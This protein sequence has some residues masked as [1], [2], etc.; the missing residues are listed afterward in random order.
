MR[1]EAGVNY[2]KSLKFIKDGDLVVVVTGIH[3]GAGFTNTL[4]LLKQ[5]SSFKKKTFSFNTR[6]CSVAT[7]NL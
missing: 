6:K 1:V 5:Q 2:G 3:Q 7:N 4:T